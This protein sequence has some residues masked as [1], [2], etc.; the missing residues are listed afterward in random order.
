ML[1]FIIIILGTTSIGWASKYPSYSSH[2]NYYGSRAQDYKMHDPKKEAAELLDKKIKILD[3]L[4]SGAKH[5]H[6]NCDDRQDCLMFDQKFL[7]QLQETYRENGLRDWFVS[8]SS[9]LKQALETDIVVTEWD[10]YNSLSETAKNHYR[11]GVRINPP[12]Q[13]AANDKSRSIGSHTSSPVA[14]FNLDDLKIYLLQQIEKNH[15]DCKSRAQCLQSDLKLVQ[16]MARILQK[17]NPD[18]L[19]FEQLAETMQE[20]A[21][22]QPFETIQFYKMYEDN[23]LKKHVLFYKSPA[24]LEWNDLAKKI[25]PTQRRDAQIINQDEMKKQS[26]PKNQVKQQL[27]EK[28]ENLANGLLDHVFGGGGTTDQGNAGGLFGGLFGR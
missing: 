12:H 20:N 27:K 28:G 3:E 8:L 24:R 6:Q 19:V 15:R 4:T 5:N 26:K 11:D 7:Q 10:V 13:P 1:K 2:Y 18:R 25:R 22:K 23:L 14:K 21:F 16:D 17:N 9:Q